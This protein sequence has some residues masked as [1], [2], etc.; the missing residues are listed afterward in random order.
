MNDL[1]QITRHARREIPLAAGHLWALAC[2][3][4][5]TLPVIVWKTLTDKE[6]R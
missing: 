2:W 4:V 1:E 5:V 6:W 3:F